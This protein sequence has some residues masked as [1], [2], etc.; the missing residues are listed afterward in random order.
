MLFVRSLAEVLVAD[1]AL[2]DAAFH[3]N[4]SAP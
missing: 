1:A 2:P 4:V 3:R